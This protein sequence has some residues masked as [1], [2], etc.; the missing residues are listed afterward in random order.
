LLRDNKLEV[1]NLKV[2]LPHTFP[3]S[4]PKITITPSLV[5]ELRYPLNVGTDGT[6][7]I[8]DPVATRANPDAPGE[9]VK[10][11]IQRAIH[12]LERTPLEVTHYDDEFS[13]YWEQRYSPEPSVD[14]R[15]LSLIDEPLSDSANIT[16]VHLSKWWGPYGAV[17]YNQSQQF[18]SMRT[19][20]IAKNIG[21]QEFPTFYLG[22]LESWQPPFSLQNHHVQKLVTELSLESALLSYLARGPVRP[23]FTF[24]KHIG[25]RQL[26]LGWTCHPLQA[27]KSGRYHTRRSKQ[28]LPPKL[29]LE[30]DRFK[31]V[32][33]F[34]PQLLTIPRL[35]LRTSGSV[36]PSKQLTLLAAGL[37]SVGSQ[38]VSLVA[39][40]QW[41]TFHLVDPDVLS[42]ENLK[43]HLF[44]IDQ[45][46]R[47]KVEAMR[48]FL[49]NKNPLG[50]VETR[51]LGIVEVANSEAE[52]LNRCDFLFI[53]IGDTNTELWL[54]QMQGAGRIGRPLFFIWVEPYM[55]GGHCV[56]L[57][58]KDG[59]TFDSLFSDCFYQFN[60]ISAEDYKRKDFSL[61]EAGCQTSY[62]PYDNTAL[63]SFLARLFPELVVILHASN[64]ASCRFTWTG[65]LDAIQKLGITISTFARHLNSF[66][67]QRVLL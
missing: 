6:V 51:S 3:L 12:I 54:S 62:T 40:T 52:F 43:R 26:V 19:T 18:N 59:T 16:Y 10:A 25:E 56:F 49:L 66:Q 22:E 7:C 11:C 4:L 46:G 14:T 28:R 58:G 45:V 61:R 65:D 17:I 60:V 44:G 64:P 13:A 24:S 21:Y 9:L 32:Q 39:S 57:N 67:F 15:V 1:V 33:R 36:A 23:I 5:R 42:L 50:K 34:S 41:Q 35:Q 30:R 31:H 20:L 47:L 37:G 53:A 2:W 29:F 63:M 55:A 8:F 48:E 27:E 38:L